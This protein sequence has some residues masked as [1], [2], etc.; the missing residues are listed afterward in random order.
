[1]IAM[2]SFEADAGD[3]REPLGRGQDRGVR[4][5]VRGRDAVGG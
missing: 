3:L 5:G 1:M 4:A 2:A